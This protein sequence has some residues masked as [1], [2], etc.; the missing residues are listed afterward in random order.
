MPAAKPAKAPMG[1]VAIETDFVL[2]GRG[3]I[4]VRPE[5]Y[6]WLN[7]TAS[8]LRAGV[9]LARTMTGLALETGEWCSRVCPRRMWSCENGRC[10]H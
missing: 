6:G 2:D 8:S 1:F 9:V 3:G 10:I 5:R 7:I 4:R